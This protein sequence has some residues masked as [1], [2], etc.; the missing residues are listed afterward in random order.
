MTA[1]RRKGSAKGPSYRAKWLEPC[2]PADPRALDIL[3][4]AKDTRME[5]LANHTR[6]KSQ[7]RHLEFWGKV[8]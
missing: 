8:T 1:T 2:G 3:V 6:K 7:L 4:M 5:F